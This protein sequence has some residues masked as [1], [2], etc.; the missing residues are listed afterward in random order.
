MESGNAT[1]D[2]HNDGAGNDDAASAYTEDPTDTMSTSSSLSLPNFDYE[3]RVRIAR[4][5]ASEPAPTPLT[6]EER[7]R[8][9]TWEAERT[10]AR[11][12]AEVEDLWKGS[13]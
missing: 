5:K 6:P 11:R 7:W 2:H 4:L 9:M 8:V 10:V 3:A 12:R 13:R 1:H